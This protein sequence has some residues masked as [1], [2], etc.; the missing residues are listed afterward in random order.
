MSMDIY[1]TNLA[2]HTRS[3]TEEITKTKS[4]DNRHYRR[5]KLGFTWEERHVSFQEMPQEAYP[6]GEPHSIAGAYYISQI[7]QKLALSNT[8]IKRNK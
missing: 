2:M 8:P 1:T 3:E 4:S 6:T 7:H 5:R